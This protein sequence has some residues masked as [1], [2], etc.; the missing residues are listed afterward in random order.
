MTFA[1]IHSTNMDYG[2]QAKVRQ[3]L[4]EV[5]TDKWFQHDPAFLRRKE[6]K[7]MN[8]EVGQKF[9]PIETSFDFH[10]TSI[11]DK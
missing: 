8:M 1:G 5:F 11:F 4:H 9:D 7:V 10:L 6:I 3:N 2:K